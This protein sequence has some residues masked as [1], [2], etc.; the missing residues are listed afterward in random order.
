MAFAV[1]FNEGAQHAG[2]DRLCVARGDGD[3]LGE[4]GFDPAG[5]DGEGIGRGEVGMVHD[6]PM[7]RQH[8]G[9]A[10]HLELGQRTAGAADGLFAGCAGD[11]QLGDHRVEVW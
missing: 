8:G 2:I 11:D 7:E 4:V 9:H 3:V 5:V 6:R 10:F 1:D